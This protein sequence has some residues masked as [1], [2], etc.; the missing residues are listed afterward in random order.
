MQQAIS[1]HSLHVQPVKEIRWIKGHGRKKREPDTTEDEGKGRDEE[2]LLRADLD[3]AVVGDGHSAFLL[4]R[5]DRVGRGEDLVE[6]L[7]RPPVGLD[8]EEVPD[9]GLDD[10]PADEHVD[11]LVADVAEGDRCTQA[12]SIKEQRS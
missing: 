7:E 12:I 5:L 2:T 6:L 8:R 1:R 10:V 11:V 4:G 9:D 3:D